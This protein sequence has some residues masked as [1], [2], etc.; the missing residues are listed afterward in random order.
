MVPQRWLYTCRTV[1]NRDI[2][3]GCLTVGGRRAVRNTHAHIHIQDAKQEN[4]RSK[5]AKQLQRWNLKEVN[6][7]LPAGMYF[8]FFPADIK[9]SFEWYTVA[10]TTFYAQLCSFSS[11]RS[12]KYYLGLL[13]HSSP[14]LRQQVPP[15]GVPQ[16]HTSQR[17]V[18]SYSCRIMKAGTDSSNLLYPLE[19]LTIDCNSLSFITAANGAESQQFL[20]SKCFYYLSSSG[21]RL[22]RIW[23][24]LS[25]QYKTRLDR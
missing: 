9:V 10:R 22:A 11:R 2:M 16:N 13:E 23:R 25:L 6:A 24:Y 18:E 14:L 21:T 15:E 8:V 4:L 12:R 1:G 7:I 3:E 19:S 20:Q 5:S 17:W